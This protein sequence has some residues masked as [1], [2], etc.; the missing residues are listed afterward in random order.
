MQAPLCGRCSVLLLVSCD[1]APAIGAVVVCRATVCSLPLHF[2]AGAVVAHV[3]TIATCHMR[4]AKNGSLG[5]TRAYRAAA[6]RSSRGRSVTAVAALASGGCA[7]GARGA[8]SHVFDR[9]P[10]QRRQ[11]LTQ[12]LEYRLQQLQ[13]HATSIS[14][15]YCFCSSRSS[16]CRFVGCCVPMFR[17]WCFRGFL[18]IFCRRYWREWL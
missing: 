15:C 9:E 4:A 16:S 7:F 11:L 5:A 10:R 6:A 18:L 1:A 13:Q 2:A 3:P 17:G 12:V 14:C 8:G